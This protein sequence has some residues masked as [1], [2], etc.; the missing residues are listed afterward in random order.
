[1]NATKSAIMITLFFSSGSGKK[2][3]TV[4]SITTLLKNLSKFHNIKVKRRWIF[5]CFRDLL[6]SGYINRKGRY[7]HDA[8]GMITQIPSMVTFTM[9]GVAWLVSKGVKGA[10]EV[11]KSIKNFLGKDDKRW[12]AKADIEE[13][14]KGEKYKPTRAQWDK[15]LGIVG[16]GV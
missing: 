3:Y 1:M 10:R 14:F 11:Y 4:S 13:P 5:Q 7:V 16:N 9:K 15:L 12:P 6:D 8:N 2:H